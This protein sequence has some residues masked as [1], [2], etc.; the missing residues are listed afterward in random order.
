MDSRIPAAA[1]VPSCCS[2]NRRQ[3]FPAAEVRLRASAHFAGRDELESQWLFSA[4]VDQTAHP[5]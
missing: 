3:L 5:L 1:R 4:L 2:K